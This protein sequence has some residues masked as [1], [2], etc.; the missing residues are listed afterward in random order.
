MLRLVQHEPAGLPGLH[1]GALLVQGALVGPVFA[2]GP[3]RPPQGPAPVPSLHPCQ[4]RQ[5]DPGACS[6]ANPTPEPRAS[7]QQRPMHSRSQQAGRSPDDWPRGP[8]AQK[9]GAAHGARA[10]P[11]VPSLSRRGHQLH[12]FP[13][14]VRSRGDHRQGLPH[15]SVLK[16]PCN[17]PKAPLKAPPTRPSGAAADL[18]SLSAVWNWL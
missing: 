13:A 11:A 7:G 15:Q 12:F 3:A 16:N 1:E 9:Q 14:L 2:A 5:E 4:A 10:T 18:F 8:R 6:Q 17:P